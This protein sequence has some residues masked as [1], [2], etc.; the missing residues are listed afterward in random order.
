MEKHVILT[1]EAKEKLEKEL[2]ELKTVRRKEVADRIKQ[3]I[4]FGDISENSEYDD[5]KNEQA[6][7]E[8]RIQE[9]DM[10]LRNVQIIDE[11]IT[12]ADVISIGSTVSVRDIELDELETYRIVGTVEAD[13]MQNKI[14][15]E[16]PVGAS[17]LGKRAGDIVNVPAPIGTIQY[18]I[19]EV[20]T[21]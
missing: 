8:G 5:A 9:L 14:S 19:V 1:K 6:F 16:S 3:A 18:E 12:Q 20:H 21:N 7:I 11:E 2:Q 13:P 15:N 17:L 4:D 10:M